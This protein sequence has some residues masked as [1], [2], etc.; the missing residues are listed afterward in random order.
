MMTCNTGNLTTRVV[1]GLFFLSGCSGGN[2]PSRYEPSKHL[3]RSAIDSALKTWKSGVPLGPIA[4]K[5]EI[6]M[7]DQRWQTGKTLES[8][9]IL[10]EVAGS[11]HPQFKVRLKITGSAEEVNEFL[12]V[13]IDPLLVF[14][15]KDYR[16]ATGAK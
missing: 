13:G 6:N 3:A 8:Y 1:L 9:E 12:A 4:G 14:R 15:E 11:E 7:F 10:D 16:K 2:S 5:P